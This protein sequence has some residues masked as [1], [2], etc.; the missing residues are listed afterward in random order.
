[1]S[2]NSAYSSLIQ[3][4]DS[5]IRKFYTNEIIRGGIFAAIYVLVIFQTIN[6]LEYYL[7]LPTYIRKLLF[8]GFIFSSLVV[9]ARFVVYPALQYFKLGKT[10]SHEKASTIIGNHFQAV[11]DKLLN[12]LQL[13]KLETLEEYS[14]VNASI[15]QKINEL[16]PVSF[17]QAIDLSENKRYLKYLLPPF[18]LLIGIAIASP[19]VFKQGTKR[20][21]YND[22]AFEKEAPFKFSVK[23]KSLKTLQYEDFQLQATTEGEVLPAE[24]FLESD[25]NRF[26]MRQAEKKR[27]D[28]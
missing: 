27:M 21:Y 18:L 24:L 20:L 23:N 26:K 9:V 7:Y 12:I 14:L 5:F 11:S 3:K 6:L 13:K 2:D 1:M 4:L 8:F 25:G 28:S 10:I 22:V 19:N 16:R 15:N 17:S